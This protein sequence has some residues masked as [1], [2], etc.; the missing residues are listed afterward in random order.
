MACLIPVKRRN[1]CYHQHLM[2]MMNS[3]WPR[4]RLSVSLRYYI[5]IKF[6]LGVSFTPLPSLVLKLCLHLSLHIVM[7]QITMSLYQKNCYIKTLKTI[8]LF[9]TCIFCLFIG[10]SNVFFYVYI[11]RC[12]NIYLHKCNYMHYYI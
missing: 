8:D 5:V 7:S 11:P 12:I 4:S 9:S 3:D 1:C 6:K 2:T 10:C